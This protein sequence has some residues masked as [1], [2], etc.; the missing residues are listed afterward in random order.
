VSGWITRAGELSG[1]RQVRITE[2][3]R[4]LGAPHCDF[5]LRWD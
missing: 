1:A 3:C 5:Q 2:T 4:L